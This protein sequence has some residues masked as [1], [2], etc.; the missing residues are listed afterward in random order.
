MFGVGF[1]TLLSGNPLNFLAMAQIMQYLALF[2]FVN[3]NQTY[4]PML[5]NYFNA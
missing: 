5:S 2:N 3:F 4:P 1:M